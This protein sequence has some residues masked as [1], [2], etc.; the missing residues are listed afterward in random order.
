MQILSYPILNEVS[1]LGAPLINPED[2]IDL[3][4]RFMV[5][6]IV[7]FIVIRLLYYKNARRKDYLFTYFMV[8]AVVFFLCIMLNNVKLQLGFALGLFAIFGILRYRT[9]A[10]P[11]KEMTYLF[12]VIGLSV[13]NALTNKKVSYVEL[14]FTNICVVL[15]TWML[16]YVWLLK[17]ESRK[18]ITFEK[19]DLV[20]PEKRAQ[21]KADLEKRT[22]IKI[23][24]LEVGK[25]DFL[26]DTAEIIIFYYEN[27]A[28]NSA[29]DLGNT[30]QDDDD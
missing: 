10:I 2:F 29:N 21:L 12:I 26:R 20:K 13:I 3:L 19:I 18:V 17:H 27:G 30:V 1:F 23:S 16:E 28:T 25:I 7:C 22:G 9:D 11:I 5:N 24:R 8:S 4:L 14:A 6:A 15:I